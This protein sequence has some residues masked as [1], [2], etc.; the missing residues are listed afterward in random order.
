[1]G[2]SGT[3]TERWE[4]GGLTVTP[5]MDLIFPRRCPVCQDIAVPG[6]HAGLICPGCRE[7]LPYV[8]GPCCMKCGKELECEEQEYCED[9]MRI[10]KHYVKG[11]PVFN[12]TEPIQKGIMAFKY[13]NRREYAEFYGEEMWGRFGQ[14]FRQM[15]LDGI[16]PV[17]LHWRKQRRR[18]YN[19]AELLARQLS[20]RLQV[21]VYSKLL[22][23]CVYTIPQK[24]LNDRE[25]LNNLKRAFL[26]RKND[27]KLNRILLVD[28]IYTTGATIEACTEVLQQA[29]I[30]QIYYT[31]ICI[32]KS[33]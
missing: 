20:R 21:P 25:R 24:E 5:I 29:G 9:C 18:G 22:I 23:R 2:D 33:F 12:Y 19:Q 15:G 27:V 16:L 28:D 10:P 13:H 4:G 7:K 3:D 30:E 6:T 1:M 31:S 14:D 17:P 32:G 8:K 26:F 11:Y